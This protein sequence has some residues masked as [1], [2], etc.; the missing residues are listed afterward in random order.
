MRTFACVLIPRFAVAVE[1]KTTPGLVGAVV[2]GGYPYE[3][4]T[5]Y[6]CSE[7]AAACGVEVGISLRAAHDLC[8]EATFLPVEEEKYVLCFREM[9]ELLETFSPLVEAEELGRC[10]LD[11]RGLRLLHGDHVQLA[12]KI[13]TAVRRKTGLTPLVGVGGTKFVAQAAA[14]GVGGWGLGW[15]GGGKRGKGEYVS[16]LSPQ[17][18]TP[19]V[20]PLGQEREF[21]A[22]LPVSLLPCSAWMLEHLARLGIENIGELAALPAN[23]MMRQFGPEGVIAHRLANGNDERVVLPVRTPAELTVSRDLDDVPPDMVWSVVQR[24]LG[25]GGWGLGVGHLAPNPQPPTPVQALVEKLRSEGRLCQR[26]VLSLVR[27]DGTVEEVETILQ[28]PTSREDELRRALERLWQGLSVNRYGRSRANL[29]EGRAESVVP[30]QWLSAVRITLGDLCR[31]RGKVVRLFREGA[32]GVGTAVRSY[33]GLGGRGRQD[34]FLDLYDSGQGGR[35]ESRPY[36]VDAQIARVV[37]NVQARLGRGCL[38]RAVLLDRHSRL[39]ER[40]FTLVDRGR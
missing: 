9:R 40:R 7:E 22:P 32:V 17:P 12:G 34:S 20:V 28:E 6:D 1:R 23:T 11:V 35:D 4:K 29:T 33:G 2:I 10:F 26:V 13:S 30:M 5:V 31:E 24:L 27:D 37:D 18:P 39:P 14:L 19:I 36:A 25:I 15:H 21:L 38:K 16:P 3:R 8:P